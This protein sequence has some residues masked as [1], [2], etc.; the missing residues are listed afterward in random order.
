MTLSMRLWNKEELN[1]FRYSQNLLCKGGS[2]KEVFRF[3]RFKRNCEKKVYFPEVKRVV[4]LTDML[5]FK[6]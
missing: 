2:F 6:E 4:M 5:D 1:K 3:I